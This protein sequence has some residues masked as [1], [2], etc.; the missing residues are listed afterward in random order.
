AQRARLLLIGRRGQRVAT[1]R[2]LPPHWSA[3]AIAHVGAAAA[4]A[5]HIGVELSRMLAEGEVGRVEIVYTQPLD[6]SGLGLR[7]LSLFPLDLAH[8]PRSLQGPPPLVQLEP[9]ALL[10][11]LAVE[12]LRAQLTEAV[13][14]SFAAENTARM[15]A[16]TAARDN[17]G[18]T[19]DEL[20]REAR[21]AR[22]EAIT[23]EVVELAVGT[24]AQQTATT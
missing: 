6:G 15:L 8:F 17:I 24:A 2:G 13:L 7:R 21:I 4:L 12:Y 20:R 16:M 14:L 19:L 10:E 3:P 23:A 18:R 22:Q 11:R 1:A 9:S 5:E